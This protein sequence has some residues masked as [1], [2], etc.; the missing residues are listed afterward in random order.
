MSQEYDLIQEITILFFL[1]KSLD[2]AR[3]L[4]QNSELLDRAV[5][6]RNLVHRQRAGAGMCGTSLMLKE[7][8]LKFCTERV[9]ITLYNF[10]VYGVIDTFPESII[11]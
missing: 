6:E 4:H 8:E 2:Y 5:I 11:L 10:G 3:S 1:S 9:F 7:I